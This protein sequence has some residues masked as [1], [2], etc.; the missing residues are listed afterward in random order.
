M[1]RSNTSNKASLNKLK[2]FTNILSVEELEAFEKN[3]EE[4]CEQI[5]EADWNDTPF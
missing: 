4:G 5:N 1:I 3:I 2:E